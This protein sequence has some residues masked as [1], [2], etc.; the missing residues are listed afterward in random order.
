MT[1]RPGGV[2]PGNVRKSAGSGS[3]REGETGNHR[4][5]DGGSPV[6]PEK[7]RPDGRFAI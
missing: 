2:I 1:W 6:R 4:R 5:I 3:R 7:K